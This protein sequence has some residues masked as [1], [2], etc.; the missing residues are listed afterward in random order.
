MEKKQERGIGRV[1]MAVV[2]MDLSE[3]MTLQWSKNDEEVAEQVF[4]GRSFQVEER[5]STGALRAG[6]SLDGFLGHH[7]GVCVYSEWNRELWE[8]LI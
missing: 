7:K 2:V 5:A 8:G 4:G 1:L 6:A 3:M